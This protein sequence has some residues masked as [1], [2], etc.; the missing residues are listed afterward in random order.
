MKIQPLDRS[1]TLGECANQVIR[2]NFQ[3]IVDQENAVFKDQ[4]PE[5]LHQMRVGLRRLST[6]VQIFGTA[7][8]LPKAASHRSIERIAQSLGATRDLDVLQQELTT[9]YQPLLQETEQ[10]KFD[11][12]L[13]HLR[14]KRDKKFQKMLKTLHG[15]R[16]HQLKQTIQAW[17]DQPIYTQM[18]NVSVAQSLPDLLLPLICG[19]FLHPGWL[20]GTSIDAEKVTLLPMKNAEDLSEQWSESHNVL[21]DLRQQTK[22]VRYQVEFFTDFYA[23]PYQQ[24]IE[25]FKTIQDILG[26]FQ[27]HVVLRQFLESTLN[28]DLT[29]VLPT[30]AQVIQQDQITLWQSWQ[31]IQQHYLASDF[32]QLWRS[33]LTTTLEQTP[34]VI[35]E[36]QESNQPTETTK[37]ARKK[38]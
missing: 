13:K 37:R 12:V 36:N 15:D 18:R 29:A 33:L 8:V 31:P 20:V 35:P 22:D 19:L 26:R 2:D 24:K 32:R 23:A 28:A 14:Q 4:D 38:S 25:E 21:H 27:D 1:I 11:Q 16:H 3:K 5:S 10:S 7:I 17:L 9:R 30:I 6:A 34:A